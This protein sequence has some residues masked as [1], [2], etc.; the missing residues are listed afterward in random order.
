MFITMNRQWLKVEIWVGV[1]VQLDLWT[2]H[3]TKLHASC[4]LSCPEMLKSATIF[5]YALA[6]LMAILILT[7]S[8]KS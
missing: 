1:T 8:I 6:L 4:I 3:G 2:W 7:P 5:L